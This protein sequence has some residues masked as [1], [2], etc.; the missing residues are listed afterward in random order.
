[1]ACPGGCVGGA[2]TLQPINKAALQVKKFAEQAKYQVADDSPIVQ[3]VLGLEPR[4]E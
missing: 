2:G 4:E 3:R 1:M